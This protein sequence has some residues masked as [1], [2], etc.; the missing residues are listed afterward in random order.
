MPAFIEFIIALIGFIV[1]LP[2]YGI[3]ALCIVLETKG[4]ALYRANRIG[5]GESRFQMLKFRTMVN[6]A[7]KSG[8]PITTRSD[9]RITRV[10][11]WLRKTKLDE[12]PQ[13]INILRGEMKFV[14]PRP[15]DPGIVEKY[16]E[17]EKHI[18]QFK[19][20]ITSPASLRYRDE[21]T[22]IPS[23]KWEKIYL[24]D[25]LPKKIEMD[26]R[27]MKSAGFWADLKIIFKTVF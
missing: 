19:P 6:D 16:S 7:D 13:L 15:E 9:S 26:L 14:G 10:G 2:F 5:I 11:K 20:G 12:L 27:Y 17:E 24:N 23:D 8:P 25:I 22:Q 4:S 3:I 18:F 21:E 1:L